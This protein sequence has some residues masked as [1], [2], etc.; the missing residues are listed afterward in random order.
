MT[1]FYLRNAGMALV[2]VFACTLAV[3]LLT[4][5]EE[6]LLRGLVRPP[7]EMDIL[8]WTN[9]FLRAQSLLI[10]LALVL[11]IAWHAYA[12]FNSGRQGD[13]QILWIVVGALGVATALVI[14][15]WQVGAAQSGRFWALL[16]GVLNGALAYWLATALWT[17][18]PHKYDPWGAWSLRTRWPWV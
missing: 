15:H 9:S 3:Y 16:F 6:L 1:H 12:L 14:G 11:A 2:G 8:E 17:P 5:G 4:V 13:D 18:A 7:G 10:P